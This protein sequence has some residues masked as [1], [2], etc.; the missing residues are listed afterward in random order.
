[1]PDKKS[2][3]LVPACY[4]KHFAA[5]IPAKNLSNPNFESGVYVN[6]ST[7]ED[8]WK[9][10][11]VRHNVFTKSY[12]YNLESD[13]S[14]SPVVEIYLSHIEGIYSECVRNVLNGEITNEDLSFISYFTTLQY[15]RVEKFMDAHQTIWNKIAETMDA[16]DG[17]DRYRSA[18]KDLLKKQLMVSDIRNVLLPHAHIAYNLTSMP[19]LTSDT[20]VIRRQVNV[21]DM[22][23]IL[24]RAVLK[25]AVRESEEFFLVYFPLS[26]SVAFISSPIIRED[27]PMKVEVANA[28]YVASLNIQ[29][30]VNS[31]S[32]VYSSTPRPFSNE[33]AISEYLR[34]QS[35][36]NSLTKIYTFDKR[37]IGEARL[38]EDEND[39]FSLIFSRSDCLIGLNAGEDIS[40][41]EVIE[42]GASVRSMRDCIIKE[43]DN[44]SG[45]IRIESKIKFPK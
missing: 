2:Q 16:F 42:N 22:A 5:E 27:T 37:I 9:L 15:M 11:G 28:K 26:P 35:N 19:L 18:V 44:A 39:A 25:T 1:M 34:L 21:N 45:F 14:K 43:I 40:S 10:R 36:R 12:Y 17:G 20:P 4:L 23:S 38:E 33:K 29:M 31:H 13:N 32:R 30:V 41:V 24:P 8:G 6:S 7:L 3:H